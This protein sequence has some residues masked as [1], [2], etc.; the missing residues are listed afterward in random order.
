MNAIHLSAFDLSLAAA[1]VVSLAILSNIVGLGLARALLI[2]ALR[3]AVQLTLVGFILKVLFAHVHLGWLALISG[4]M[5]LVAGFEVR[6]R[7]AYRLTGW[8]GFG[9]GTLSMFIS[10]F[11]VAVF[12]LIAVVGAQPWYNPQ[13][14]IPLLGMLLGNTMTAVALSTNHLSEGVSKQRTEIEGR[15][16]LGHTWAQTTASLRRASMR[17][18]MIPTINAMAV[19]G[20]VSLPGMMTGQIL[21]GA[22]PTEA[23][24]YQILVMFIIAAATGGGTMLAVS[25]VAHRLFDERQRLRLDRFSKKQR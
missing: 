8:W 23:V 16:V 17:V 12:A 18:G 15:L 21:A 5:L 19:A 22:E 1:L 10:A 24:K 9:T 25:F 13:Y 7:Q 11:S 20:I 14:A 4:I 2:A 6:Q 3:T